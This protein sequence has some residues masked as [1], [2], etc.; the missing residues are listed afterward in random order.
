MLWEAA[1]LSFF[2]F[3]RSGEINIPSDFAFDVGAHLGV[4]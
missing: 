3:L 2:G 1:V 4:E